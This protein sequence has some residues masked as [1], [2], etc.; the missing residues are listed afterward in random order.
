[1]RVWILGSQSD[2]NNSYLRFDRWGSLPR[3]DHLTQL[4][5]AHRR[6]PFAKRDDRSDSLAKH[7]I[8]YADGY[9][10]GYSGIGVQRV[11]DV[12]RGDLGTKTMVNISRYPDESQECRM[13]K[14]GRSRH[15]G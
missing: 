9:S 12:G 6:D 4:V 8:G 11:L 13:K 2:L 1:M 15:R 5:F 7:A 3:F 10:F 14:Y